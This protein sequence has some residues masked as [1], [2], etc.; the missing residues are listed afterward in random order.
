VGG[1][2]LQCTT[3]H[4]Y[5]VIITILINGQLLARCHLASLAIVVT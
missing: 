4:A 2:V 5:G 1:G 3:A